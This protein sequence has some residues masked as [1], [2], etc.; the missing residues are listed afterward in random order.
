MTPLAASN[1]LAARIAKFVRSWGQ[2]GDFDQLAIDLFREQYQ[3]NAPYRRFC[4]A[5]HRSPEAVCHW[6]QIPAVPA[7]AF[8]LQDLYC[9]AEPPAAVFRTS[10]TTSGPRGEHRMDAAGLGMYRLSLQ[11]AFDQLASQTVGLPLRSLIAPFAEALDSSLSFMLST[12]AESSGHSRFFWQNGGPA[13]SE[14]AMALREERA[15]VL[16]FTTAFAL[17]EL[18]DGLRSP[19]SLPDGSWIIE[20]GGFKGR[21]KEIPRAKLY[22][23]AES[24]LGVPVERIASEYGMCEMSSQFYDAYLH[25]P[26]AS[27]EPIKTAPPWV[28]TLFIDPGTGRFTRAGSVLRHFDL[29]NLSSVLAIETMDCARPVGPGFVLEGRLPGS[30]LRGCSLSVEE[31]TTHQQGGS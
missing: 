1:G 28:R 3:K 5:S 20:T 4:D 21:R 29:C 12:L 26:L 2:D 9:G 23:R 8:R 17:A 30:A 18:L 13:I 14:A 25:D 22:T 6:T 31:W 16:I 27:T 11:T 10:G 24:R 7:D 19:L 15:P